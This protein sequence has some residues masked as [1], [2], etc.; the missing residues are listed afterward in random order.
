MFDI[1]NEYLEC[2]ENV[3]DLNPCGSTG[4]PAPAFMTTKQA[5]VFCG[6]KTTGALRKARLEGRIKANR[7]YGSRFLIWKREDLE[8]FLQGLRPA[9]DA[10]SVASGRL[11]VPS[12]KW[13]RTQ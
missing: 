5:S 2:D 1:K 4:N 8:R 9:E 10:G 3:K 7:R 11:G 12:K 6:Y 13:S